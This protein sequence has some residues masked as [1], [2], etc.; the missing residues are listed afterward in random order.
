MK[1]L[2]N[3]KSASSVLIQTLL[4]VMFSFLGTFYFTTIF[5]EPTSMVGALWA[6]ISTII[7]LENTNTET[8]NSAKKRLIGS[9]IGAF[10]SAIYLFFFHF[11]LFGFIIAIGIGIILC[12]L[13]N[14]AQSIKLTTITIS[15]VILVST[16][17]QD[18][19]PFSNAILR[20]VESAIGIGVAITIAMTASYVKKK[21]TDI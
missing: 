7:V 6:V 17:A 3:I 16:V 13:L 10:I 9:F 5:H 20:F 19:N 14:I 18:L 4:A 12:I 15:I 21:L 11:T 2:M 1:N 8:F